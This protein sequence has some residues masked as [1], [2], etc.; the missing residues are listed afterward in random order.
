MDDTLELLEL[1]AAMNPEH[2]EQVI[3][4]ARQLTEW[5]RS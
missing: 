3:W 5:E 1:Y 2:R 4:L